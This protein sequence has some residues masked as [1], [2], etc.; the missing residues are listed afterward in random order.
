MLR[1]PIDADPHRPLGAADACRGRAASRAARPLGRPVRRRWPRRPWVG[2]RLCGGG[3]AVR[4]RRLPLQAAD[5]VPEPR[6]ERAAVLR[7]ADR[8]RV[9]PLQRPRRPGPAA[10]RGQPSSSWGD[11]PPGQPRTAR[12]ATPTGL[13]PG[14]R[15]LLTTVALVLNRLAGLPV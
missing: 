11:D 10:T 7:A 4:S 13:D 6:A 2:R 12:P 9:Q 5:A 1:Q 8:T 14:W 15:P 3:R